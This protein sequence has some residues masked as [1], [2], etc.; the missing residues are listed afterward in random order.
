MIM[1]KRY[2][3]KEITEVR[4]LHE[5]WCRDEDGGQRADFSG[6]NLYGANLRCANL[7][8]A[9]L[10][11]AN[12]D[13]ANLRCAKNFAPFITVGP[14]GSRRG[15]T[16]IYLYED[17]IRC[18]C[19]DG[20]LDEFT[21][22][23]KKTHAHNAQHLSAYLSVVAMVPGMLAAQ[24]PR[25]VVGEENPAFAQGARVKLTENGLKKWSG[26]SEVGTVQLCS[27]GWVRVKFDTCYATYPASC[28]ES[29][30]QDTVVKG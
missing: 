5:M 27:D 22:A 2:S 30:K 18:G 14:I 13:G 3:P 29:V 9:N 10:D 7:Y 23:I 26:V 19:F 12:L 25:E 24:P 28:L 16:L 15:Y 4:R 6:A 21:S 20:T 17:R 8:G 1:M 11:G